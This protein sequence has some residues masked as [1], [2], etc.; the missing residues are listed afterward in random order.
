VKRPDER[1]AERKQRP[2]PEGVTAHKLR[3]TFASLLVAIYGCA[4]RGS[5]RRRTIRFRAISGDSGSSA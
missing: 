4:R 3:H 1:L 5:P 2:L